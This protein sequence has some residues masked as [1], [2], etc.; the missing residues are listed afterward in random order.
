MDAATVPLTAGERPAQTR[1]GDRI[2]PLSRYV[3]GR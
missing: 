3:N 1:P 2:L